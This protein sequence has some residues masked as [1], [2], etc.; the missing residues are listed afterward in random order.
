MDF[1][2]NINALSGA[3]APK[4]PTKHTVN[5][6]KKE[7]HTQ[8]IKVIVCG[9]VVIALLCVAVV[10]FGVY[11]QFARLSEA[12]SAY[13]AVHNQ[14]T[15]MESSLA[16]YS[17]VEQEYHTYARG[18]MTGAGEAA[19]SVER[20]DV[21]DLIEQKL[22]TAGDV[23]SLR[24]EEDS[25]VAS[26]SGMNL[27]EISVMLA[28]LETQDAVESAGVNIAKTASNSEVLEFT[29]DITLVSTD[30]GEGAQ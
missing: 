30:E 1:A 28:D 29:I 23:N 12:E 20:T 5:L 3:K 26:M 8:S 7:T 18:W 6:A 22:M 9:L 2:T 25:V 19:V 27:S 14:Y 10:K 21:L 24:I 17:Q 11:D 13:S 4:Y 15:S 16:N